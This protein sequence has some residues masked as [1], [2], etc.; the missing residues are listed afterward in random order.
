M[1]EGEPD[2][3][4][5]PGHC[6]GAAMT[7]AE[8]LACA[9]PAPMLECL[10]GK[11]SDRK[12]RLFGVACCR[13]H[14]HLLT[15]ERSRTAVGVGERLADGLAT[16][17]ERGAAEGS[18]G[19]AAQAAV[20]A[21]RTDFTLREHFI[22]A[23]RAARYSV[24]PAGTF[25]LEA[26]LAAVAAGRLMVLHE[27]GSTENR[28]AENAALCSTLR[29][30]FGPLPLRTVAFEPRWR[31]PDT[32]GS[33]GQ[34]Y[35]SQDFGP[36]PILA[37]ALMDAG[38]DS[39]DIL[40]YCRGEG[41]HVR[42][43]WVVDLVLGKEEAVTEAE[44]LTSDDPTRMFRPGRYMPHRRK[45][46]L[47]AVACCRRLWDLLPDD[48]SRRAV[49]VAERHAGG[50]ATDEDLRAAAGAARAA[51]R[52]MFAAVG[53]VGSC[54]EW[55]AAFAADPNPY[56]AAKNVIWMAA[57]PRAC[58]ARLLRSGG[59]AGEVHLFPCT[60]AARG[61]PTAA[62]RGRWKVIPLEG[63][64]P[65]PA[66]PP[67]QATL[68]R[69]IYGNPF[70]PIAF[71][72]RWRTADVRGLAEGIYSDRAFDRLPIL[73]DALM[74][75]GCAGEQVIGHCRSEGLHMRGCWVVDLALGKE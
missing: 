56:H 68:L 65:H 41:Q 25:D 13:R 61:G 6:R 70:R 53:K 22:I 49:D 12:L 17:L 23:A 64:A 51:H 67:V 29:D 28:G 1:L 54:L 58:E 15:D 72:P 10:R 37:D 38:C 46:R 34:M 5:S 69:D 39:E 2:E 24:M 36:M 32:E 26:G 19:Q 33:A 27:T 73:A 48:R 59:P 55:A 30:I 21:R 7:E 4:S 62:L 60:V 8:W 75:A 66:A 74:D 52:D 35:D 18:V 63:T 47:F 50:E 14:W 3:P 16:D 71:D 44:W 31:T 42:G 9:D 11:G 45:S 43:C 20:L 57:T 40:N